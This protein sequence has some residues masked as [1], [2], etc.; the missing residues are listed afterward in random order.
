MT[1][2]HHPQLK[3]WSRVVSAVIEDDDD[4]IELIAAKTGLTYNR[5]VAALH[6]I[7]GRHARANDMAHKIEPEQMP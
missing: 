3:H 7:Q 6:N 2:A 4:V 1:I 5:V